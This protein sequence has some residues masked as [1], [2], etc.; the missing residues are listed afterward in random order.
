M[1]GPKAIASGTGWRRELKTRSKTR[2]VIRAGRPALYPRTPGI[3]HPE[4]GHNKTVGIGDGSRLL[5]HGVFSA[6][7]II[8]PG[9][10]ARKLI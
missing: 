9:G 5:V 7:R 6:T 3:G 8:A 2:G 1:I 4:P 10:R